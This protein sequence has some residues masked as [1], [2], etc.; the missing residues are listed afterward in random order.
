MCIRDSSTSYLG[1]SAVMCCLPVWAGA[2]AAVW[3]YTNDTQTTL[4]PSEGAVLG[5]QAVAAGLAIGMVLSLILR[6]VGIRDDLMMADWVMNRMGGD[7]SPPIRFI[8][9]SA[10]IR[11]SRMPTRRR[12]SESTMPMARPAATACRP[13]T[14]PSLGRSVVCVSFV[15][16]QTAASA[17]AH[18]GRQHI[19]AERPR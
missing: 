4:R 19:T 17:P 7:M 9:Q 15:Y 6:L 10:I 2:L 16:F 11:S 8:T 18:T 14:A 12:I 13:S 3:K 5:L 1:L